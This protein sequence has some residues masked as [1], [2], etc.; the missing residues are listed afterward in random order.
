MYELADYR[1]LQGYDAPTGAENLTA[2]KC[3]QLI[4]FGLKCDEGLSHLFP[5]RTLAHM[6]RDFTS[7][8]TP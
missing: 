7:L 2:T 1:V 6:G 3:Q 8:P 4:R 5:V